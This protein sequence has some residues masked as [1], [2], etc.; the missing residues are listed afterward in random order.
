MVRSSTSPPVHRTSSMSV[1]VSVSFSPYDAADICCSALENL[2]PGFAAA[3]AAVTIAGPEWIKNRISVTGGTAGNA[4]TVSVKLY[5]P[6]SYQEST[7]TANWANTAY[8]GG[9]YRSDVW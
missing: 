9:D 5:Y 1:W 3:L 2:D 4:T 7:Q 6:D 8:G